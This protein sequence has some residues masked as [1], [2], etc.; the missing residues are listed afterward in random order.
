[1]SDR[2]LRTCHLCEAGCGLDITRAVDGS[3]RVRGDIDDPS[4]NGFICPKGSVIGDVDRDPDRVRTPLIREGDRRSP[5]SWDEAFEF[6]AER[7]NAIRATHGNDAVATFT[8]NPA[9]HNLGATLYLPHLARALGTRNRFSSGSLDSWPKQV[10]S[11][12]LFGH[13]SSVP[14]PDLDRARYVLVLGANPVVSNGSQATAADWPGRLERVME[15]GGRVVVVDP[16]RTETAARCAEHVFLRPGTDPLLLLAMAHHIFETGTMNLGRCTDLVRNLQLLRQFVHPLSPDAVADRTGVRPDVIRRLADELVAHRGVVYGRLGTCLQDEGTVASW[17]VDVL[18]ILCGSLD[19]PGGAM[20]PRPATGVP[21]MSWRGPPLQLGRYRSSVSGFGEVLGEL[22][23]V[24]MAEEILDATQRVRALLTH[25][26][27]PVRSVPNGR[28]VE[29]AL[30]SLELM[31]SIDIYLNETTRFAHVLLPSRPTFTRSFY[32]FALQHF[33]LRSFA[34]YS[35]A[36]DEPGD[37]APDDWEVLLRLMGIVRHGSSL[38]DVGMLD[39]DL[40]RHLVNGQVQ[41]PRSAIF[42]RDVDEILEHLAPLRGPERMLDLHLRTGPFGD[43]FGRVP[44]G[45]TLDEVR[46]HPHGLDLGPLIPQLPDILTTPDRT[47]D[48]LPPEIESALAPLLALLAEPA[49]RLLLVGRRQLQSNNSWMHNIPRLVKGRNRFTALVNPD[50]AAA[51]G[52]EDGDLIE[53]STALGSI[54][55]RCEETEELMAGVVSVPHGWGH[56]AADVKLGVARRL[57][58]S[59]VNDIIPADRTE[60]L[61][62]TA[63]LSG[64]PITMSRLPERARNHRQPK[65]HQ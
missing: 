62:R 54:A 22:P 6:I 37:G 35:P 32:P 4:S 45:V 11:L 3:M 15:R 39:D 19:E 34:R 13:P 25:S 41:N 14:V 9:Y 23:A 49:P 43:H 58:G 33:A 17:A 61:T 38:E 48:L 56:D 1:V 64:V 59:S 53:I 10:S 7:L 57:A 5:V 47:I 21:A 2:F 16:R 28:R 27:N 46:R 29:T 51:R 52:I 50:D 20:F 24:A 63:V 55:I 44:T 36:V 8:G 12:L 40:V 31:V 30:D 42:E 65:G 26:G 60:R 18:N